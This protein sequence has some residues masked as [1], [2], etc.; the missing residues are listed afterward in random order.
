M[1]EPGKQR[2]RV[3]VQGLAPVRK[4]GA[5]ESPISPSSASTCPFR[6]GHGYDIHKLQPNG[7]MFLGG[8]LVSDQMSPIAHSDGDVVIHALVD[9][10]LG[11]MGWGDIGQLFSDS[12]P[13]WKGHPG[14]HFLQI[15]SD[16]VREAGIRAVNVDVTILAE[17]P[18]I[19][20]FK[21]QMIQTLRDILGASC[22]INIKAG[23]NEGCD[24]IGR[25]EAI[26]AHAVVLL[27]ADPS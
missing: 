11:A 15:V 16:R 2:H 21:A 5:A 13:Q 17:Q 10:L 25:A 4:S 24:A 9:A 1:P 19:A 7:K 20:P 22:V 8:V 12:D 14:R 6:I 23:T 18:R 26:A 3:V 27:A